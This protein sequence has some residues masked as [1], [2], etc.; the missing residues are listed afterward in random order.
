MNISSLH[1]DSE[2]MVLYSMDTGIHADRPSAI[3]SAVS[4][5]CVGEACALLRA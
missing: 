5:S 2:I 1:T 4:L 3:L